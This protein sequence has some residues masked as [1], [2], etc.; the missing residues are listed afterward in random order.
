VEKDFVSHGCLLA[1][2]LSGEEKSKWRPCSFKHGKC[3]TGVGFDEG[4]AGAY[5]DGVVAI[6]G[7]I[8]VPAG[9]RDED[10]LG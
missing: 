10:A 3:S 4:V 5:E 7:G 6:W 1:R 9:A 8:S 2:V